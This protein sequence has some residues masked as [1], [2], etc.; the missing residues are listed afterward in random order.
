MSSETNLMY[1]DGHWVEA[2]SGKHFEV[3]NPAN[4]EVVGTAPSGGWAEARRAV[5]AA[6]RAFPAWAALPAK[7][8]CN[9]LLHV[10]YEMQARKEQLARL[11]T[12]EE[13][14]PLAE[15]E[16][17]VL[18]AAE[19]LTWSAE[20]AKR[21]PGEM[22]PA[23]VANKRILVLRQPIGVVAAI[24]PWNF[25]F[26]MITRKIGPALAAGC[27]VVVKPAEQTPLSAMA[28]F[29]LFEEAGFP[30][31]AVNLVTGD[32]AEIGKEFLSNPQVRKLSFTGS[33]EVGK[34]LM[35]GAAEQV[36]RLSLELGGHAPFIV[37]EDADLDRAVDGLV[38]CK[39]RNAGQTCICANRVFVQ[40]PV[41]NAFSAKLA[42]K[43]RLLKVG[44][45]LEPGVQLGP[46]IDEPA[47]AKVR[48]HVDDAVRKGAKA[49]CGGRP[50]L[51]GDFGKGHFFEPTVLT[52]VNTEMKIAVEETFGPVAPLIPFR[53]EEEVLAKA[54]NTPY[55]LAAYFYTRDASRLFRVMEKLEYGIVG[56]ND[57]A[58]AVPQAPF[59]GYKESGLGRE[60]GRYALEEYVEI[61]NVSIAI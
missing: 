59:G 53:S 25:P 1:V 31:G 19:F 6:A 17:E 27:T 10:G 12:L 26:A 57:P 52:N 47:L 28:L 61:K 9:L 21:V 60:G 43:V 15:A 7:E 24:T 16:A 20:E 4:G 35:R 39:F 11:V 51:D 33:T 38:A 49:L 29:R 41:F 5:V 30:A 13:G 8:R 37:F 22:I 46:L 32:P 18:Y 36:K 2:D 55:G 56:A 23:S 3:K 50:R 48:A 42:D 54:N 58:P 14:K 44:N 45:G 40:E 34:L